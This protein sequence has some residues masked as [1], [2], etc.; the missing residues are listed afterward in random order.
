MLRLPYRQNYPS[1]NIDTFIS[2]KGYLISINQLLASHTFH[3]RLIQSIL[4]NLNSVSNLDKIAAI[5]LDVIIIY[6]K[7]MIVV[8]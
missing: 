1:N 5:Q 3:T 2:S 4:L 7:C 8:A 6:Y